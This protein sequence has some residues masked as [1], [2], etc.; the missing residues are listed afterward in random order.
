MRRGPESYFLTRREIF[1]ILFLLSLVCL[2]SFLNYH[3]SLRKSTELF[4][5][6]SEKDSS[7]SQQKDP[8]RHYNSK[9]KENIDF[10]KMNSFDPN[11]AS[12][13]QLTD[14]GFPH[15]IAANIIN[16]REKVSPFKR[17]EDILRLYTIDR[18]EYNK[19][20]KYIEIYQDPVWDKPAC[21]KKSSAEQKTHKI[22]ETGYLNQADSIDLIKVKGIGPVFAG[23]IIKYRE[24][25][26]GFH[27]CQQL[28]EV[29]NLHDSTI[30]EIQKKFEI[31]TNKIIKH[32]INTC[33]FKQLVRHPYLDY[34]D[35]QA[36][37]EYRNFRKIKHIDC[38]IKEKILDE[39]KAI[40]IQP[41]IVF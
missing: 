23:R 33:S 9:K 39:K 40:Q 34:H 10:M 31:D 35:V 37:M 36:I 20:Y 17:K 11:H 26:G 38:L 27:S 22:V 4:F 7:Y 21:S 8:M 2:L 1:V 18:D 15:K 24:M 29:Y 25:L 14:R 6:V 41:Y 12:Y 19:L 13:Q 3:V 28:S 5:V 30:V 16:Y 32:P